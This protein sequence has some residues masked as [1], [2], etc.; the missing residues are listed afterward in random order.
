[1][2]YH[3]TGTSEARDG[4]GDTVRILVI[5]NP[6]SGLGDAGLA[7]YIDALN[8][9]GATVET[10]EL[11]AG[12]HVARLLANAAEFDRVV[13]AGGDG[14]A[15]SVAYALGGRGIPML[16][17]PAGTA[18]LLA[19]N[20]G[21]PH[22]PEELAVV[23]LEGSTLVTDLGEIVAGPGRRRTDRVGFAGI[24]GCGFDATVMEGAAQL[25]PTIGAGAYLV[26]VLM[27]LAPTP[28]TFHI[29]SDEDTVVTDGI[30]VLLVNFAKMQFDLA[31]THD[32][33]ATDGLF[34]VVVIRTK[35]VAGL[36]PTVW[37]A[38][39][40]RLGDNPDRPSLQVFKAREI[41][42][43]ADPPLAMQYDGEL[44]DATTP[45]FARVLPGAATFIVPSA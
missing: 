5:N 30:A 2:G 7:R 17:Y 3:R 14:T 18:N 41:H 1:M 38:L 28:A 11:E 15:S 34:E 23:T 45:F 33:D 26:S 22:D 21:L 43:E 8:G 12:A 6:R 16:A 4:S 9:R 39:L 13:A 27:N 19:A 35:N 36:I 24:A 10:R 20:L 32:S 40:D 31:V 25:K 42:V 44:V 29:V 37:A